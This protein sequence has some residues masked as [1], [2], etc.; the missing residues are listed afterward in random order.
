WRATGT[1][2]VSRLGRRRP[3]SG[4]S[5]TLTA[6]DV[7]AIDAIPSAAA[8]RPGAPPTAEI[9]AAL[10]SQSRDPSAADETL[11]KKRSRLG[12]GVAA[13][14]AYTARSSLRRSS[15]QSPALIGRALLPTMRDE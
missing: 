12:V 14:A 11:R 10:N 15:C 3:P 4:L 8:R 5:T 6:A 7:R 1:L 2:W 13:I 9:T